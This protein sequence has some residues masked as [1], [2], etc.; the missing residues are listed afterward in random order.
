MRHGQQG[1]LPTLGAGSVE[2]AQFDARKEAADALEYLRKESLDIYNRLHSIAEDATFVDQVHQAYPLIPLLPNL[3]CGSWYS[4]P[5][6]ALDVPA[7]F[8]STDGHFSNWS[9]NLRRA[10]LHLLRV[11][12]D[13]DGIML[14]DSTR[15]GKR[16]P[17][18]LSKTV[19]IWCAVINRTMALRFPDIPRGQWDPAL[20][21]PPG[22]VSSQEHNQ[23]EERLGAWAEALHKSSFALPRLNLPLRP[24]WITPTTTTLPTLDMKD[25][26]FTPVICVSASKQATSG[27]ERRNG[28]FSYIQGSGDDHELWSMGLTPSL[29]WQHKDDLLAADRSQLPHLISSL[30]TQGNTNGKTPP[31]PIAKVGGRLSICA[32][33]DLEGPQVPGVITPG[34]HEL[35][36]AYIFLTSDDAGAAGVIFSD[37]APPVLQLRVPDGKKGQIHFLQDALPRSVTYIQKYLSDRK[38]I[39]I[40]C[41][42]GQDMSVGV[43]LTALQ[44]F[45]DDEGNLAL[46]EPAPLR[47]FTLKDLYPDKK[48]IRTR[49]E[50]IIS[51]RPLANPSRTTLKR[52]NEFLL[53]SSSFRA[54]SLTSSSLPD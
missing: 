53:T 33:S 41:N 19:P 47:P 16:I 51:S 32:I 28:G 42:T 50:W 27:T 8:K 10:N 4:N 18:A 24:M 44:K 23:I 5:S 49:L 40:A 15:A 34:G 30:V 45:F 37:S 14:V 12:V 38:H 52:V 29:F 31:S 1:R 21:T 54:V 36:M 9:F 17:D 43:A 46:F 2:F 25:P 48:S 26:I 39:C 6:I 35:D 11:V 22:A 7:Y 13:S 20:Y 3:R